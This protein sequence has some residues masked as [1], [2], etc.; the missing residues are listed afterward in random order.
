MSDAPNFDLGI[1]AL[2]TEHRGQLEL[3]N[4]LADALA[5]GR[6]EEE[7]GA[8][9]EAL[10]AYL[11]AHFMSEQITMREQSY[12]AYEA[13]VREHEEALELMNALE[14][15]CADGDVQVSAEI[16][17]ALRGWLVDHVQTADRAL[18]QFMTIE[19]QA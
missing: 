11:D 2:D 12:P 10:I 16:L 18:A 1:A 8:K 6:P 14:E 7:I 4:R 13:H 15:R 17:A 9:L 5:A 19:G 3:M